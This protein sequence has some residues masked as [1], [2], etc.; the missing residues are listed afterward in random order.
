MLAPSDRHITLGHDFARALDPVLLARDCGIEPDGSQ[1]QLLT[2]TSKKVL[3]NCTRQFGKSTTAAILAL[4][5][6]LY[7]APAMII[8]V[9][10]SQPQSTELYRKVHTFWERLEGAPEANQE[11]LT[12]LSLAN[13]SR[14]ISLPGSEKTTRGYSGATLVVMDEA[15]RVPD[16]LLAAV[17]PVLATTDGRFIALSTPKGKRGWFYEAWTSG[18]GDW[19]RIMV[20]GAECPRISKEF[21]ADELKAHGPLLFAQEYGCEFV[22]DNTAASSS[23]LGRA[24]LLCAGCRSVSCGS[25]FRGTW[26]RSALE[27]RRSCTARQAGLA[28][29]LP[30]LGR[31]DRCCVGH[32]NVT[33][34]RPSFA[35]IPDGHGGRGIAVLHRAR[36]DGQAG[37]RAAQCSFSAALG[38]LSRQVRRDTHRRGLHLPQPFRCALLQ[39]YPRR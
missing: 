37:R 28:Q 30:W 10:P 23:D 20:K 17:R 33:G 14:I 26:P 35:G 11:S 39:G 31:G 29:R 3:L 32:A 38:R 8:L 13:G 5:E 12:R 36:K 19:Q 25:Q 16:E 22:D 27:R 24:G 9:S 2:G 1:Q 18:G 7:V 4:H 34:R 15:A 6:A 21:L